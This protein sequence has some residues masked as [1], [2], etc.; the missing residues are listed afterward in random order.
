[1]SKYT[2]TESGNALESL[3]VALDDYLCQYQTNIIILAMKSHI[4][5]N[6]GIILLDNMYAFN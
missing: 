3:Q 6:M 1:M 2:F 5:V 4:I